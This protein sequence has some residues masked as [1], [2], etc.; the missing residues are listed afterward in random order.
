M[1]G[2]VGYRKNKKIKKEFSM[3]NVDFNINWFYILGLYKAKLKE[4]IKEIK[5]KR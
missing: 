2:W 5:W 4:H 3:R 1:G